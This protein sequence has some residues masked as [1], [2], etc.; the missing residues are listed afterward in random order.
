MS[1]KIPILCKIGEN[2][3]KF[4]A[5]HVSYFL[6]MCQGIPDQSYRSAFEK[7]RLETTKSRRI[8]VP[9]FFARKKLPPS[10]GLDGY[11]DIDRRPA[12]IH[13]M[14]QTHGAGLLQQI[15]RLVAVQRPGVESDLQLLQQFIAEYDE[16]AFTAIV[17]RHGTMVL[18]VCRGVLRHQQDAED[19]F[20][21][22]FL[23]LARKAHTIR[24]QQALSSWLHGVAYRLALKARTQTQRRRVRE[25]PTATD[26]TADSI[27]DPATRE[28]QHILH[29]ELDCLGEK[30]RAP[31]LL[32]YWEGK[33][34][35]EAADLLGMTAG[36]FKKCLER[37]RNLL[38]SR[39]LRR[40][41]IPSAA[42][43]ATLFSDS[44]AKAAVSS[45]LIQTT[46]QSSVAFAAGTAAPTT[47]AVILAQGAI[48]TMT[49]T[50]WTSM[51]LAAI[52]LATVGTGLGVGA[53]QGIGNHSQ[54]RIDTPQFA[55]AKEEA[56]KVEAPKSDKERIVGTWRIAKGT[57]SGEAMPADLVA[58]GR[59]TF[60]KEGN[61]SM[62]L[63]GGAKEG[64]YEVVGPGKIDLGPGKNDKEVAPAIYQ[65][66]GDDKLTICAASGGKDRPTAFAAEK[67]GLMLFVLRRETPGEKLDPK[68]LT[69]EEA[70]LREREAKVIEARA[71][72]LATNNFKQIGLAMHNYH[73]AHNS[74]PTHAIYSKD[75]KKPLLSWRVAI[76]PYID[77]EDLYKEFKLD[78]PWDSAHNKKLIAKMPQIFEPTLGKMEEGKTLIQVFT[79]PDTVF[80]GAKK[81]K[82]T[83]ITDG[84][85]NTILA[86]EAKDAVV[87]TQPS[88]LP[89][90]KAKD[91]MPALGGRFSNG[92]VI[93]MCDGAVRLMP[94]NPAAKDLRPL[95][96]PAAGD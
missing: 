33:T 84:T 80:N 52:F 47:A 5:R 27:D 94:L 26:L 55:K 32:C 23:V 19:V 2:E 36:A 72:T 3:V 66:D 93:V 54:P 60:T 51:L 71:R 77:Q 85:S 29:E 61:M 21:A 69:P 37:A 8:V 15:R 30:Y 31:L 24:K 58:L 91:K 90:P 38:A 67:V 78:E 89:L 17:Q 75:G 56:P 14:T 35:D 28:L 86:V 44:A 13:A 59:L 1:T 34:R 83:D 25:Q 62:K 70:R 41:L 39:L 12:S 64:K 20:Q 79:G 65:F 11:Y 57:A 46:A 43:F 42:L 74:L 63:E 68:K 88:D 73:D 40:G 6:I 81:M 76:L 92:F 49:I 7:T 95:I 18:G 96:T 22:A 82:L 48:R 10:N 16:T 9:P 87:W 50:K 4:M 45:V 53:Y